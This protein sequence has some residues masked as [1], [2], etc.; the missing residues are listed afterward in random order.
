MDIIY[1]KNKIL[2]G[3]EWH[4]SNQCQHWPE[5]DFIETSLLDPHK[6]D[7]ICLDCIQLDYQTRLPTKP[8]DN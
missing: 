2:I 7:R 4:F 6:G 1:R 8:R 3:S 5:T